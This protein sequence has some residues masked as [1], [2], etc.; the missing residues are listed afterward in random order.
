MA[1]YR[2]HIIGKWAFKGLCTGFFTGMIASSPY[3]GLT[4]NKEAEKYLAQL[5]EYPTVVEYIKTEND[6]R[7]SE[8]NKSMILIGSGASLG[9]LAGAGI[10]YTK[11]R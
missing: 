1:E 3:I 5:R 4:R 7:N 9:L 6:K 11:K 8:N 10:A 2:I